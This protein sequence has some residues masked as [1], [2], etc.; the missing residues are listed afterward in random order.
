M[1]GKARAEGENRGREARGI[2]EQRGSR[3]GH[4]GGPVSSDVVAL[5]PS[6]RDDLAPLAPH[7][8]L[9]RHRSAPGECLLCS[10]VPLQQQAVRLS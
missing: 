1:Q 9:A 7:A 2:G 4:E 5:G 10:A 8:V 6:P 3:A